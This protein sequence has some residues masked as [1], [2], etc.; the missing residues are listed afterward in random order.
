MKFKIALCDDDAKLLA[1]IAGAAESILMDHGIRAEVHRFRTGEA[2][3]EA[4]EQNHFQMVLLDIDMPGMDGIATGRA[5]R[6]RNIDTQIIYVSEWEG[7]VFEA[8]LNRPFGFVR[9]GQFLTDLTK[10]INLYM[11]LGT[12]QSNS[13]H[14]QLTARD[15]L[16]TVDVKRI[17]YFEG[18]R[19]M[20][21]M[22]LE[23]NDEPVEIK[24]TMNK[25]EE[26]TARYGFIRIHKGYLV[27]HRYIQRIYYDKLELH[28]GKV[29]PIG[30]SKVNE[31]KDQ[32]LALLDD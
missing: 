17:R 3:L 1:V 15:S 6:D 14:I 32:F 9:K 21:L 8:L 5:I 25:L 28:D 11:S 26:A 30:R 10:V 4:M 18:N 22:Y 20:Q 2:L 27:N 31:V 7:R 12:Q 23:G 13:G 16:L 19:N 29:L 24:M